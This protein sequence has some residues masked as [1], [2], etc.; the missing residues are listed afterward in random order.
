M[1]MIGLALLSSRLGGVVPALGAVTLGLGIGAE[2]DLMAFFVSRYFGLRDYAKIYG[3]MF[4]LFGVGT[5]V[6]PALS[7]F[8][9][10]WFHSYL[11]IF[12]VYEAMLFVTCA[13]F[14]R[15][16]PYPFPARQEGL[17]DAASVKVPA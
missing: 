16:G 13:I 14:L 4:A 15:L 8:S 9:F 1:P 10:D 11:P 7:G 6:G 17:T 3:L 5:G 2:V 12:M